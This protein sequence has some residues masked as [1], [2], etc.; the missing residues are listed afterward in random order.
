MVKLALIVCNVCCIETRRPESV[1]NLILFDVFVDQTHTCLSHAFFVNRGLGHLA[2]DFS[3][4]VSD[5]MIDSCAF[6]R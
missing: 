2:G 1:H 3:S 6:T 4:H 5:V